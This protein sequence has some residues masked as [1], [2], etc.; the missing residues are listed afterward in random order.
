[1]DKTPLNPGWVTTREAAEAT[2]YAPDYVRILAREGKVPAT[3]VGGRTW[4]YDLEALKEYKRCM[5]ELG[6]GRHNPHL[7]KQDGE[8]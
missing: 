5:D 4:L 3:Q 2:G 1:M 8:D 6:R 7:H